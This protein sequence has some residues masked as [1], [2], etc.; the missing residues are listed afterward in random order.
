MLVLIINVLLSPALTYL[1]YKLENYKN[2]HIEVLKSSYDWH[3]DS[4]PPSL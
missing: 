3:E 1:N 4:I 2:V